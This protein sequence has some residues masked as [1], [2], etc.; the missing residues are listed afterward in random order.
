VEHARV[1]I[2]SFEFRPVTITVKAGGTVAWVNR[3]SAPHTATSTGHPPERFGTRLLAHR[4]EEIG[5][6]KP[7]IYRYR[8]TLH[9]YMHGTVK[10]VH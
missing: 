2:E 3:D 8:C 6:V 7:G 4:S 9:P 5:F 1:I 10:V